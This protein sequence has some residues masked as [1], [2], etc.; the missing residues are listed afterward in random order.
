MLPNFLVC[1]AAKSGTTSVYHFLRNR[2]EIFMPDKKEPHFLVCDRV[3]GRIPGIVESIDAYQR[4]FSAAGSRVLRGEASVFYLYFH[5]DAISNIRELLGDNT[6]IV[7][8]LRNPVDR[9]WSA[10]LHCARQNPDENLAFEAALALEDERAAAG[11]CSPML[12]YKSVGLYS[13][14]VRAYT[15]AFPHCGIFL[16]DDLEN[17]PGAFSRELFEFLGLSGADASF[18]EHHNAGG[19]EW[20]NRALGALAKK[21]ATR[22]LRDLSRRIAPDAYARLKESLAGRAM[23]PV[24]PMKPETR[25]QLA[26]F[27]RDDVR[28]L[29]A[30]IGRDLSH[31]TA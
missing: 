20:Q 3:R 6:R 26:D 9:A 14:M 30:L 11:R 23:Q 8:M 19:R 16:F 7:I 5:Q 1:G 13:A 31:W 21:L 10:Y 4:L 24:A 22:S 28:E 17:D 2:P 18:D 29:S 15:E 12:L 25:A 27:F